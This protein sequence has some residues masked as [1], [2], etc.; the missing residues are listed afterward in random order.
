MCVRV[1]VCVSVVDVMWLCCTNMCVCMVFD[2]SLSPCVSGGCGLKLVQTQD[3]KAVL[4]LEDLDIRYVG[5]RVGGER[6]GE[7]VFRCSARQL[8]PHC[9][10]M[11][12]VY[13]CMQ[14]LL[15]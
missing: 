8:M 3:W 11:L 14:Q 2:V 13:V 7:G 15:A 10:Y 9:I 4:E 5:L 6:P 1:C 12:N